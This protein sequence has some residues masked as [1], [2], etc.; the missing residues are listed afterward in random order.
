M[1]CHTYRRVRPSGYSL[2][3]DVIAVGARAS[4]RRHRQWALCLPRTDMLVNLA[5][6]HVSTLRPSPASTM[7]STSVLTVR[8]LSAYLHSI[9]QTASVS[10]FALALL[11]A[12][13]LRARP[14]SPSVQHAVQQALSTYSARCCRDRPRAERQLFYPASVVDRLQLGELCDLW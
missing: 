10:A 12:I 13:I 11:S 8:T 9:F 6:Q 3:Q 1:S 4:P 5:H 2:L 7:T 14:S